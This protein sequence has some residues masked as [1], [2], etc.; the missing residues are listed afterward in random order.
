MKQYDAIIIGAGQA[1]TPLSKKLA[2][3]GWKTALIEKRFIGGTCVNDGC[4]PT[5]TLIASAKAAYIAAKQA[6]ELGI[7]IGSFEIDFAKI[8]KRKN[9][10]VMN[11]REGSEKSIRETENLDLV[12]GEAIFTGDKIIEVR[13]TSGEVLELSADYFF[14]DTGTR[15][16]IPDIEGIN[17]VPYLTSTSI[18]DLKQLPDHLLIL[19]G[20][21]IGME[22]GQ[23]FKRLGSKV[24]IID[25]ASTFLPKEDEDICEEITG[26]FREDG[27]DVYQ[28][29][30][31]KSL[32]YTDRKIKI[33]FEHEGKTQ[34][35]SGDQLLIA[36]GRIP[37]SDLLKPEN[38][39]IEIDEKGFIKVDD[40]LQTN[41]PGIYAL[42]EANGGPAFT[43]IAFNDYIIVC[44]NLLN[45]ENRSTKDRPIPYCMFTDPQ[46]A[47]VGMTEKQAIEKGLNI[48]VAKLPMSSV[49][50]GVETGET[51]GIM[52][53]VVDADTHKILGVAI[54]AVEGGEVMSVLEIAM[55]AGMTYDEL[56]NYIFAHPTYS[57]SINNLFMKLDE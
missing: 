56:R 50:R 12:F 31:A 41:V 16:K 49:A 1:G 52:K 51:R 57:E 43:H 17:K 27:I 39:G 26:I 53:A 8:M 3:A 22:F 13:T 23:L 55:R 28:K 36:A 10:I 11:G 42:G 34:A 46:L 33:T 24:T 20:G 25:S 2:K 4:T 15:T 45:K 21:Y 14:I 35:V 37:Q 7:K 6:D 47:R 30:K 19:G 9:E 40:K 32:E 29:S 18:L 38:S 54:L 48:K 44:Y 5:K